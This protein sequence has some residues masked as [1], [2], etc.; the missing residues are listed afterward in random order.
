[1]TTFWMLIFS[2]FSILLIVLVIFKGLKVLKTSLKIRWTPKH[3]A[4]VVIGYI[5][6][7]LVAFLY[8][9]FFYESE[10]TTLSSDELQKLERAKGDIQKYY[11]EDDSSFLTETYKKKNWHYVF[12][13]DVLPVVINERDNG[14]N[15]DIRIR[16]SDDIKHGN[17]HLSYYQL[18]DI[19]E[20]I[21]LT[22]Q[23][24]LPNVYMFDKQ[25]IIEAVSRNSVSYNRV[26]PSLGILDINREIHDEF[27]T[28]SYLPENILLIEVARSTNIE[29]LQ[30]RLNIIN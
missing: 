22:D 15:S 19:I 2:L 5:T 27:R 29:D 17:V 10:I 11:D 26:N 3:I 23:M 16:Y 20:G 13:G 28:V 7:G 9:N 30:G 1:M 8:L 4:V 21:D 12:E 14:L 6:L 25:L 18:P 24:P